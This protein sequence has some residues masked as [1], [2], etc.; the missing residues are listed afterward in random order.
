MCP[1]LP[2]YCYPCKPDY[3]A[4]WAWIFVDPQDNPI[5]ESTTS[6]TIDVAPDGTIIDMGWGYS[7]MGEQPTMV[8][9]TSTPGN[10]HAVWNF[11]PPNVDNPTFYTPWYV[12]VDGS[13]ISFTV[14][15]YAG[16]G[17]PE[18]FSLENFTG[19]GTWTIGHPLFGDT[20]LG[21]WQMP[22]YAINEIV[23]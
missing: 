20:G 6:F 19:S 14:T 22:E 23:P 15:D 10:F 5:T 12:T 21:T 17:N 9:L 16:L 1:V 13:G 18:N 8:E 3:G 7:Y 2:D 11:Y 4:Q